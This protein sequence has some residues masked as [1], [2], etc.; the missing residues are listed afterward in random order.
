[1]EV[2]LQQLLLGFSVQ[3]FICLVSYLQS[4]PGDTNPNTWRGN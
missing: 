2:K 3:E 4:Q 1:M